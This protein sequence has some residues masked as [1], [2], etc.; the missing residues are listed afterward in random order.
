[1]IEK[2]VKQKRKIRSAADR[3]T[4][5]ILG[6]VTLMKVPSPDAPIER[7]AFSWFWERWLHV[8]VIRE[9]AIGKFRNT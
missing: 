5:S 7:D 3:M 4:G 9:R 1:M 8:S 6:S 2:L